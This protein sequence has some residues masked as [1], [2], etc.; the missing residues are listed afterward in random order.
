[1]GCHALFQRIFP[2]QG[3][4]L[5]L[6]WLLHWRLILYLWATGECP[7]QMPGHPLHLPSSSESRS[8]Q[9]SSASL[10]WTHPT[11]GR[12][13]LQYGLRSTKHYQLKKTIYPLLIS[14]PRRPL[15]T[16]PW[17]KQHSKTRL[18]P[19]HPW[20]GGRWTRDS[21]MG[22]E[23]QAWGRGIHA[24]VSWE[25]DGASSLWQ[26][27]TKVDY[28]KVMPRASSVPNILTTSV[29]H[30]CKEWTPGIWGSVFIPAIY[31]FWSLLKPMVFLKH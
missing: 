11:W 2:K 17:R 1:M 18:S 20:E 19:E 22:K 4:N 23:N 26:P 29:S 7:R 21:G 31:I 5:S 10:T 3:S 13:L 9:S 28:F 24:H 8:F 27:E 14:A 12:P 16:A 6:L 25:R 30:I 15:Y